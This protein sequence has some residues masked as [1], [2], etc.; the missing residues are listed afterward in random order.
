[1]SILVGPSSP[2]LLSL[3]VITFNQPTKKFCT[4]QMLPSMPGLPKMYLLEKNSF[5]FRVKDKTH[6]L[7]HSKSL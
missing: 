7:K 6:S 1:M 2:F 3:T 5:M 4:N